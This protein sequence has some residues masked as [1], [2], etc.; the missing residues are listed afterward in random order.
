MTHPLNV[1]E[2]RMTHPFLK[3]QKLITHHLSLLAHPLI[4]FDQSLT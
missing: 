4:L 3:A 2:N 1:A